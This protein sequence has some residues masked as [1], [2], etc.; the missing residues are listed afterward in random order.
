MKYIFTSKNINMSFHAFGQIE[1]QKETIIEGLSILNI[2]CDYYNYEDAREALKEVEH[3][4]K[5][6]YIDL[7]T[8]VYDSLHP[9]DVIRENENIYYLSDLDMFFCVEIAE[10]KV[11]TT[12]VQTTETCRIIF[13]NETAKVE[14]G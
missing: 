3:A 4:D 9:E 6:R 8:T 13:D 10:D 2:L 5:D 14:R 11:Y 12:V 7:V 1:G